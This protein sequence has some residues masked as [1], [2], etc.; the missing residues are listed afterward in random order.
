VLYR[1]ERRKII[2]LRKALAEAESREV[3]LSDSIAEVEEI[4]SYILRR[5]MQ[6]LGVMGSLDSETKVTLAEPEFV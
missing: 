2:T 3:D 4:S 6:V 1:E 5:E